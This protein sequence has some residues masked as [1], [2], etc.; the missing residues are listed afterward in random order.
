MAK[1]RGDMALPLRLPARLVGCVA[2]EGGLFSMPGFLGD[3]SLTQTNLSRPD[4]S[5]TS[6]T[7]L[8]NFALTVPTFG[9]D[10]SPLEATPRAWLSW[11]AGMQ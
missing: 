11:S 3:P 4:P 1:G 9:L 5:H 6:D 2:E 7:Y 8:T 10:L